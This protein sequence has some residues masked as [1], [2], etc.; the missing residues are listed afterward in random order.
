MSV[1]WDHVKDHPELL[2]ALNCL[3]PAQDMKLYRLI[4]KAWNKVS[5]ALL[6]R[7]RN[8]Q[9]IIEALVYNR[10]RRSNTGRQQRRTPCA[11]PEPCGAT[12]VQTLLH[13]HM[14]KSPHQSTYQHIY[15]YSH[16]KPDPLRT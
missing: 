14:K 7:A 9:T 13:A 12:L 8:V 1:Y 15:F 3:R 6:Q 5:I 10:T 2:D 4:L 11:I 16:Y